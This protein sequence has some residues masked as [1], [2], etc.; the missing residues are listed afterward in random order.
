MPWR[1]LIALNIIVL[2]CATGGCSQ[3]DEQKLRPVD[4]SLRS[5]AGTLHVIKELQD[6]GRGPR[7]YVRQVLDAASEELEAQQ[8]TLDKA[9][10][11]PNHPLKSE[12]QDRLS[13]LR[14]QIRQLKE[15]SA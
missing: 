11:A 4:Q 5:W 8:K 15:G 10:V 3:T 14:A 2:L 12:L 6:H 13:E 1:A 9:K 7:L